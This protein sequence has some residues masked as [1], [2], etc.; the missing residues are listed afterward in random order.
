MTLLKFIVNCTRRHATTSTNRF[1][2]KLAPNVHDNIPRN[3]LFYS[4]ASFL[5]VSLTLFVN[6]PDSSSDVTIFMISFISSFEI[7]SEVIP[8][9]KMLFWIVAFVAYT[10]AV[11]PVGI[12][13][14]LANFLSTFFIFL[15]VY[16][17]VLLT[18]LLFAIEFLKILH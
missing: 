1:P 18:V 15:K 2:N 6:K 3:P 17:I 11:T 16:L 7:I 8:G 4:F 13:T 14:L 12:K 5:I 9:P 10:A